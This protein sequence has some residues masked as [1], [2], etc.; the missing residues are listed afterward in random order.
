MFD[1]FLDDDNRVG[2]TYKDIYNNFVKE[3]NKEIENLLDMKIE[4]GIFDSN[5]KNK[6]N[7]QKINENEIY[8][9]KLPPKVSLIDIL[10]NSSYRKILDS[11][12][13]S[14]ELYNEFEINY[15]FIE[16]NMTDLLLKNKK[17]LSGDISKFIY[18][19]EAFSN[20]LTDLIT[21]FKK[22]YNNQNLGIYDK[23]AVFK[24]CEANKN[25][26]NICKCII[27]DFITLIKFLN[28]KRNEGTN[29]DNDITEES[30][31]K[32][33]LDKIKDQFSIYMLKIFENNDS[34]TIDKISEIFDYYLKCIYKD[35]MNEIKKYQ[36]NLDENSKEMIK[37]Y[38]Q[39]EKKNYIS[40]KDFAYAIRLFTTLILLP[41][42]D[43]ENKIKS[44][45]N[46]LV[47]YLR[48]SDLWK[49]DIYDN[50]DFNK[51]L[52]ELKS[53][54]AQINQIVDLY[55]DLGKDIED[56]YFDDVKEQIKKE[57]S[58]KKDDVD[59]GKYAPK[60]VNDDDDK[61]AH[62][63]ESDDDDK[64][65]KKNDSDDDDDKYAHKKENEDDD[66]DDKYAKKNDS[67]DDDKYAK[68]DDSDDD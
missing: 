60:I 55:Y 15:D 32:D 57:N 12:A 36:E 23:L 11:E 40:K 39:K 53:I 35:V 9:S 18:N 14:Y 10:F 50:D 13:R 54:N 47:N 37:N 27:N 44:N 67:D 61:Y 21:L 20:Q 22:R 8:T 4:K 48:S 52:N 42:E 2:R 5:C 68:K 7:I 16:E 46:N 58:K 64:N 29:K 26:I 41:E 45:R 62:K 43:K 51:N 6:I 17:L 49:S 63:E 30:K 28:N 31:I 38:Y 25:N 59:D 66:D 24:F 19:N 56:D 34:L 65:A 33:V 3:Q 1:F